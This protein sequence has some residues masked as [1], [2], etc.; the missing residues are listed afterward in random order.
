[1]R[2]ESLVEATVAVIL[3]SFCPRGVGSSP[4]GPTHPCVELRR[5][6]GT[7]YCCSPGECTS[8]EHVVTD[9]VRICHLGHRRRAHGPGEGHGRRDQPRSRVSADPGTSAASV[10]PGRPITPDWTPGEC[11]PARAPAPPP[12]G[13]RA[14]RRPPSSSPASHGSAARP[15]PVTAPAPDPP[16]ATLGLAA[17]G[18]SPGAA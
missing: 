16:A 12:A 5:T 13:R 9:R 14:G 3:R 11:K 17:L 2:T 8:R 1:V 18:A 7:G 4:T 10:R 6:A 15:R